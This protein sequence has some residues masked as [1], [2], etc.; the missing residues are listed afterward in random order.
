[1]RY[2]VL[3]ALTAMAGVAQAGFFTESESNNTLATANDLGVYDAP[4]GSIAISGAI[5]TNDVDWFS[6]TINDPASL[7]FFSGFSPDGGDGIMQIVTAGGDVIAFDDDSGNGLMPALQFNGLA[8]G[9]Y[10][11]GISSFGDVFSDS[12]TTDELADGIPDGNGPSQNF[13][14]IISVGLS[15]DVP[16]PGSLA[17]LGM[18]GLVITR[19]RRV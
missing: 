10:F 6:F 15:L 3:F 17:L 8:A 19:R 1:M 5:G 18:G 11:I 12:V 14:Y 16:T 2:T 9:T 13:S 4:G 7:A